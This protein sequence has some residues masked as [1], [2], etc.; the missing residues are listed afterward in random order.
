MANSDP[1]SDVPPPRLSGRL[2]GRSTPPP[3]REQLRNMGTPESL[4]NQ[5]NS[6][7]QRLRITCGACGHAAE[8]PRAA[9]WKLF[10][11]H[12]TPY[13]IRRR[14]RCIVCGDRRMIATT[15]V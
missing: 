12:A 10:G 6:E 11:M 14:A 13:S 1:L 2:G 3:R 4:A 15:I 5:M 7:A 8:F 9:A